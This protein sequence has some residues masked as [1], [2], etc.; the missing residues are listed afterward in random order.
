MEEDFV[1]A[2]PNGDI[3][4]VRD[5]DFLVARRRAVPGVGKPCATNGVFVAVAA[6]QYATT[7]VG[8]EPGTF[9]A[10]AAVQSAKPTIAAERDAR[11]ALDATQGAVNC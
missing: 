1:L 4:L 2:R 9:A 11:N 8:A 3:I 6:T 10:L 7:A 5:G